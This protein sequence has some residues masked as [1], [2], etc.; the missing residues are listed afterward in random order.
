V[1]DGLGIHFLHVRS[2]HP[3]ALPLVMTHGWPG[4]VIEFLDAIGP[5]V[6]TRLRMAARPK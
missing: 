2:P 1:I 3:Q 6:P 5:L 4:S